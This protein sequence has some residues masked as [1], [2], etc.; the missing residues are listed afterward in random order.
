MSFRHSEKP[1]DW[2]RVRDDAGVKTWTDLADALGITYNQLRYLRNGTSRPTMML[3][4]LC[5]YIMAHGPGVGT[6]RA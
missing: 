5:D 3:G 6:A 1:I 2:E 4:R